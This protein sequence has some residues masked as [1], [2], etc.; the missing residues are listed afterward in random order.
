MIA[1][2]IGA[3]T[4]LPSLQVGLSTLDSYCDGTPCAHSR[5]ISW[6]G[7]EQPLYK[8]VNPQAVFDRLVSA[9]APA[10]DGPERHDDDAPDPKLAQTRALQKSVLDSVLGSVDVAPRAS[11]ARATRRA[12]TST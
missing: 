7:P 4:K 6:A 5:S 1:S 8:I 11:S 10:G 12:S 3:A 2:Q 9:G